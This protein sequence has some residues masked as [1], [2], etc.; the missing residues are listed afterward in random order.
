[1]D[2]FILSSLTEQKLPL[3]IEFNTDAENLSYT[4]WNPEEK[5]TG[6]NLWIE[7]SFTIIFNGWQY[8]Y[9]LLYKC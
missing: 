6:D 4:K 7:F 1:M 2:V 8:F 9:V 3:D 5:T